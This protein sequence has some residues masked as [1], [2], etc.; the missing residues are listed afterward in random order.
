MFCYKKQ[1]FTHPLPPTY[2]TNTNFKNSIFFWKWQ[3]FNFSPSPFAV[4]YPIVCRPFAV[5]WTAN[6]PP[7]GMN[8]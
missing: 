2:I 6:D 1:L 5:R 7:I 8:R 3:I 4:R